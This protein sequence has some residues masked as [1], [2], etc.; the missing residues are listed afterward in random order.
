MKH[1]KDAFLALT[2]DGVS[3]V[4]SD[5]EVIDIGSTCETARE[6]AQILTD[7]ALHFGSE[8]N[9]TAMIVPLGAWGKYANSTQT[10]Q[11]SFGRNIMGKRYN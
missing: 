1:G 10:V 6:A 9:A 8:D 5:Q 3:Y 2:T 11:F 4:V 7:Q